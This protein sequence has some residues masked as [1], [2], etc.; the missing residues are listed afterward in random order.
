[1]FWHKN[2]LL[3]WVRQAIL[4]FSLFFVTKRFPGNQNI[5]LGIITMILSQAMIVDVDL[6]GQNEKH[7]Q[8]IL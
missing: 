2:G 7:P 5:F 6:Y 1:M 4:L 3:K 8:V